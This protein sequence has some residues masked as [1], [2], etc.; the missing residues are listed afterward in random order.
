MFCVVTVILGG[1]SGVRG[2]TSREEETE[3]RRI[4]IF[5]GSA[6]LEDA[7]RAQRP[8][9][10]GKVVFLKYSIRFLAALSRQNRRFVRRSI[11]SEGDREG[12]RVNE[13]GDGTA[14]VLHYA[15]DLLLSDA[16]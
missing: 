3:P 2:R 6:L 13:E 1:G 11:F 12:V 8:S 9:T 7:L 10:L 15:F 14:W 16:A 5:H 4:G